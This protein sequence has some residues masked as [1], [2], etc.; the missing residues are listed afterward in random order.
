MGYKIKKLKVDETVWEYII[1]GKGNSTF[2]IF[3]G[4]GQTAQLNSDL[5]KEFEKEFKVIAVNIYDCLSINQFIKAI[6]KI[7]EKE[8]VSN[9]VIY[10][11]SLGGLLAQSYLKRNK[12]KVKKIIISHACTPQSKTFFRKIIL[13]LRMLNIFLPF[14]PNKLIRFITKNFSGRIQGG[15]KILDKETYLKQRR[16]AFNK[17]M[18]KNF[19]DKYLNKKLLKTLINLSWDFYKNEQITLKDL[20]D[21]QGKVL[22]LRTDNDPLMQDE[23][24]FEK[25]Y[26]Q[27][28][29]HTF[30]GTGHL[31]FF[32]QFSEMIQ[33]IKKF[34]KD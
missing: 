27:A 11:L 34:L 25:I 4:G 8:R 14:I 30:K 26:P 17:L 18:I 10:G 19:Y 13:P 15:D 20:R 24:I 22:I 9:I 21:W 2:L 16:K 33:I 3:P 6:N 7:L 1:S 5:I 32:Y 31:S 12:E 28:V 23:G 29:R